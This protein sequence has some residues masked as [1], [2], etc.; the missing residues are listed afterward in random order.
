TARLRVLRRLP[1]HRRRRARLRPDQ[2]QVHRHQRARQPRAA[3]PRH[4]HHAAPPRR[5]GVP[6]DAPGRAPRRP[7]AR[8]ALRLRRGHLLRHLRAHPHQ[9]HPHL[10]ARGLAG[11]R[12]A[13]RH[14]CRL[15]LRPGP[16]RPRQDQG[17][18]RRRRPRPH[19][20]LLAGQDL[21]RPPGARAHPPRR[22]QRG[23]P[24]AQGPAHGRRAAAARAQ[25]GAAA[26]RAAPQRVAPLLG[27]RHRRHPRARVRPRHPAQAGARG[28]QAPRGRRAESRRRGLAAPLLRHARRPVGQAGAV[29]RGA[30]RPARPAQRPVQDSWGGGGRSRGGDAACR[31][32]CKGRRGRDCNVHSRH[33]HN[34]NG[35]DDNGRHDVVSGQR[36]NHHRRRRRSRR[37]RRT[38]RGERSRHRT[39]DVRPT[40]NRL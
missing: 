24:G 37:S 1:R 29:R 30:R 16:R 26:R 17:G 32:G 5:R 15:P 38:S 14:G 18:P 25:G 33:H 9:D 11:R 39:S 13:P 36:D 31:C 7:A 28:E 2:R 10:P 40:T 22:H 19:R 6:P 20:G 35:D 4:L 12:A 8:R 27:R 23:P 34:N 3:Q 21:L